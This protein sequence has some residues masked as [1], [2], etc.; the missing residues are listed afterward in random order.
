MGYSAMAKVL[1]KQEDYRGSVAFLKKVVELDPDNET[2]YLDLVSVYEKTKDFEGVAKNAIKLLE[3]NPNNLNA[4]YHLAIS[5]FERGSY[6]LPDD[7]LTDRMKSGE[8]YPKMAI[9]LADKLLE[10]KQIKRA[11]DLYLENLELKKDSEYLLNTLGW[12]SAT[13]TI[14]GVRNPKQALDYSL[15]LCKLD[16]YQKSEYLDTL[17]VAYAANGNFHMAATT[18]QKAV[19]IA[20]QE[21]NKSLAKRIQSRLRLYQ[22][23]K[24]FIDAGLK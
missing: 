7:Y 16:G 4:Y 2:A 11:Y 9:T 8:F 22:S 3:I 12:M 14:K 17:A 19:D 20:I 6:E 23:G 5:N 1:E 13:S 21:G 15:H 10:K 18:A 24:A